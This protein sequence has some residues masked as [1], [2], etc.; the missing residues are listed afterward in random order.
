MSGDGFD[1]SYI[2]RLR[3][4]MAWRGFDLVFGTH[5]RRVLA[6][7]L[8][9][10]WPTALPGD[11]P[12]IIVANHVSWWDGFL[13]RDLHRE[14]RPGSHLCVVMN[15]AELRCNTTLRLLGGVPL[16]TG[17]TASV[18]ALMRGLRAVRERAPDFTLFYFPQGRIWPSFRRPLGFRRGVARLAA[19]VAPAV[20]LPVGLHIEPLNARRPTPI[21]AMGEP[22]AVGADFD[23][24]VL[25]ERR[26][27][28]RLDEVLDKLAECGESLRAVYGSEPSRSAAVMAAMAAQPR[29]ALS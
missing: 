24:D 21:I 26:V 1:V 17:S 10:G 12:L 23:D 14:L 18:R 3:Q 25:V 29:Q 7:P 15:A 9:V 6:D 16:R 13:L 5:R 27:Q 4:R 28:G 8:I 19:H 2:A 11:V 20:I 22:I